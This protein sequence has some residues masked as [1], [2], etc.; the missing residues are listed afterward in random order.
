MEISEDL[1]CKIKSRTKKWFQKSVFVSEILGSIIV[2]K[3]L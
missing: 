2:K 3:V 1:L